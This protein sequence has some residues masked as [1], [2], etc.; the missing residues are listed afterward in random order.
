MTPTSEVT[1]SF[2]EYLVIF[3][4]F[5]FGFVTTQFF[6]GWSSVISHREK[7]VISVEH[8]V[9]TIFA[10]LLLTDIW[11]GSWSKTARIVEYNVYFYVSLLSPIVFYFLSV[12]LFPDPEHYSEGD[13]VTYLSRGFKRIALLFL[14]L[15]LS[16]LGGSFVFGTVSW[17]DS[18]FNFA[19][20]GLSALLMFYR[21]VWF[22]RLVLLLASAALLVQVWIRTGYEPG[23]Q[24]AGFSFAEYLIVF[25]TFI[26]G[27]VASRFLY[28]WG[29][30]LRGFGK[31]SASKEYVAWTVLA[32]GLMMDIWWNSWRRAVFIESNI[33]NFLLSLSV[34]LMFY[35]LSAALFPIELVQSGYTNLSK[36]FYRHR[37]TTIMLFGLILLFNFTLANIA[38]E[39]NVVSGE[40]L[41]RIVAI[42]LSLTAM[43]YRKAWYHR[44]ILVTGWCL[45]ILHSSVLMMG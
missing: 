11:W 16:F 39:T 19:G 3:N 2:A 8:L 45:L 32:F 5:V 40:N 41:I 29:V 33:V 12:Y 18:Y 25:I 36:Y 10:F 31:I 24:V 37:A 34:P 22:R 26:Y 9:W 44:L 7:L 14:L 1:L 21:A 15:F 17:V 23:H 6:T 4:T 42:V 35:F 30:I 43:I 38:D 27:F 20:I 13:L 28:G